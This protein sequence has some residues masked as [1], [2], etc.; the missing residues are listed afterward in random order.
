MKKTTVLKWILLLL[1]IGLCGLGCEIGYVVI[2]EVKDTEGKP[3]SE[4]TIDFSNGSESVLTNLNGYW[5]KPHI[6]GPVVITARK[7]GWTFT[8]NNHI[9]QEAAKVDFVGTPESISLNGSA[10][11]RRTALP[12]Q[13]LIFYSII[14]DLDFEIRMS[15]KSMTI[16]GDG[17]LSDPIPD[18]AIISRFKVTVDLTHEKPSELVVWVTTE[19][20]VSQLTLD[21]SLTAVTHV[22]DGLTAKD[23]SFHIMIHDPVLANNGKLNDVLIEIEWILV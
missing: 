14:N 17:E 23:R 5:S 20:S 19:G 13:W 3:I 9:V 12:F 18:G 10:S 22:W 11:K 21:S 6:S 16:L 8:P 15:P 2:G 7:I 4:V 1:A